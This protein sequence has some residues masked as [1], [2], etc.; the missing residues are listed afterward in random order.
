MEV[1]ENISF[2]S[3]L[4]FEEQKAEAEGLGRRVGEDALGQGAKDLIEAA[5]K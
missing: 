3:S 1:K 4:S 5:R 2:S